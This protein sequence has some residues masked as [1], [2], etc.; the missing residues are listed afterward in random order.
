MRLIVF[1]LYYS[2]DSPVLL[3]KAIVLVSETRR[4]WM[5]VWLLATDSQ[6]KRDTRNA[7]HCNEKKIIRIYLYIYI[8]RCCFHITITLHDSLHNMIG[9]SKHSLWN[10]RTVMCVT[11]ILYNSHLETSDDRTI[12]TY[13]CRFSF[14]E[15]SAVVLVN[16]FP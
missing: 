7:E 14:W 10:V 8:S 2:S 15:R 1:I 9:T 12:E 6:H 3:L 5:R 4:R 11:F 16:V 13:T